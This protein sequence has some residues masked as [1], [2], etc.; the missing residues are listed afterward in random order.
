MGFNYT[1]ELI[2]AEE[3]YDSAKAQ[4]EAL[5][6]NASSSPSFYGGFD[7]ASL[8]GSQLTVLAQTVDSCRIQNWLGNT[9]K[10]SSQEITE[11]PIDIDHWEAR[12]PIDVSDSLSAI[13]DDEYYCKHLRRWQEICR[14]QYGQLD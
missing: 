1:R 11:P 4:V 8:A 3:R 7:N 9:S 6:V 2:K 10:S 13:A 14:L 12:L 5:G